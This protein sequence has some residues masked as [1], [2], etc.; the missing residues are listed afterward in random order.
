MPLP[1]SPLP[2]PAPGE[3]TF[4]TRSQGQDLFLTLEDR[5]YRVRGWEKPLNPRR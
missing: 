4:L 2:P 1:A 5:R 3:E